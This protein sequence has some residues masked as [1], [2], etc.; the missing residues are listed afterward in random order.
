MR[1]LL[2]FLVGL[3]FLNCGTLHVDC[4]DVVFGG[5]SCSQ[6]VSNCF[7]DQV[8]APADP[9]DPSWNCMCAEPPACS[10]MDPLTCQ[11]GACPDGQFCSSVGTDEH[12]VQVDATRS[13]FASALATPLTNLAAGEVILIYAFGTTTYGYEGESGC[14]GVPD[15][16]PDGSRSVDGTPCDP[17]RKACSGGCAVNDAHVGELIARI[18]NGPWFAVGSYVYH[19]VGHNGASEH[20]TLE[21]AYNDEGDFAGN[22]GAYFVHVERVTGCACQGFPLTAQQTNA[23][24][25]G[26]PN[27][28]PITANAFTPPPGAT[29]TLSTTAPGATAEHVATFDLGFD[30]TQGYSATITYPDAFTFNGFTAIGPENTRIGTYAM[31]FDSDG[32]VD[33]TTWIR[34]TGFDGAYADIDLNGAPSA[35]DAVITRTGNAFTVVAPD[36]G[37]RDPAQPLAPPGR[38]TVRLN[39]G[40]FTNPPTPGDFGIAVTVTSVDPDTGGADD[41]QGTPPESFTVETI[42]PV[43][44][45]SHADC[46]DGRSCTEDVCTDGYCAN[47]FTAGFAGVRCALDDLLADNLC[48]ADPVDA[49]LDAAIDAKVAKAKDLLAA[50]ETQ[51]KTKKR[52]AGV[53]FFFLS[54]FFTARARTW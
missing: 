46:D 15:V 18:G 29:F 6:R 27:A 5:P 54:A 40:V 22:T 24:C 25:G 30:Q 8:C 41:G 31:D 7:D 13:P 53:T 33:F 14:T 12:D 4:T 32:E 28:V 20:G 19:R 23:T 2:V 49:G 16:Q 35:P 42:V 10:D 51:T 52:R 17:P 1:L 39:A 47:T 36:G 11:E 50:A 3:A 9:S 37:D 38:V 26:V 43:G 34:S 44:C 45:T 21:L 48:G